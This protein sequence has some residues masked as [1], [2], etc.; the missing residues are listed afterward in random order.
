MSDFVK[1]RERWIWGLLEVAA[2]HSIPVRR[3]VLLLHNIIVWSCAAI[4]H[5][6]IV[7]LVAAFLGDLSTAPVSAFLVPLWALN[8]GFCVWLY[9]EGLKLNA[10]S[11]KDPRRQWWEP[12]C[13]LVLTPLFSI[14]ET[15]AIFRALARVLSRGE[16]TFTVIRKPA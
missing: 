16:P 12:L 3:R 7:V 14:W 5:P 11:S 2:S 9:W 4:A 15:V 8:V 10:L 13:L 1:Q 6:V